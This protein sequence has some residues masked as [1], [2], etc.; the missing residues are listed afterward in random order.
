MSDAGTKPDPLIM[1]RV[2]QATPEKLFRAWSSAEHIKNW[3]CP[4]GLTIPEAEIDLRTGGVFA[5]CMRLP[6]GQEFWSRGTCVEVVPLQ[7]IVLADAAESEGVK[8]FSV[9]TTVTFAAE[10][11]GTRMSVR[12]DYEIFTEQGHAAVGGATAGWTS[13]LNRLEAYLN[14]LE[15]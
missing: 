11:G 1:S 4:E 9:L 3:F 6:D 13:T 10:A 7:R 15:D 5:V 8:H 12:Q 14:T 2:F